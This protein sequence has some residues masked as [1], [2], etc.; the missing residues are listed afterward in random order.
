[1]VAL[2][3]HVLLPDCLLSA[4]LAINLLPGETQQNWHTDDSFYRVPRP[5]PALGVSA[6]W[7]ID[8]VHRRQRGDA[9]DPGQPPVG[10][11]N[12]RRT[13]RRSST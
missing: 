3:D 5:R 2:L 1:M 12:R 10:R 11:R 6:I 4:N 8:D 7:A 9:G 13:I